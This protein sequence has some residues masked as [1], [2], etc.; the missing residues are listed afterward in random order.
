[1]LIY[2]NNV[3]RPDFGKFPVISNREPRNLPINVRPSAPLYAGVFVLDVAQG[4]GVMHNIGGPE[5]ELQ[6]AEISPAGAGGEFE[7]LF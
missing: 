4:S 7:G 2:R 3:L 1:M 5:G 6:F